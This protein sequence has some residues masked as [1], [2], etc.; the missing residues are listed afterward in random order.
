MKHKSSNDDQTLDVDS[1]DF[2]GVSAEFYGLKD[3]DDFVK[4][5]AS[6]VDECSSQFEV[7]NSTSV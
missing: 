4:F 1:I 7:V 5:R 6:I 3:F 2:D